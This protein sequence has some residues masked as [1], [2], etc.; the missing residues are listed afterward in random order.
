MPVYIFFLIPWG[1]INYFLLF[2]IFFHFVYPY[3][4]SLILDQNPVMEFFI[5]YSSLLVEAFILK[6]KD[7]FARPIGCYV[8]ITFH[9]LNINKWEVGKNFSFL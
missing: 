7:S 1:K 8:P 2:F 3:Y 4:L 9:S 6:T 5:F